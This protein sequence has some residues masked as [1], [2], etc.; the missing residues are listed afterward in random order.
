[1]GTQTKIL[2]WFC[3]SERVSSLEGWVGS[4]Q[5]GSNKLFDSLVKY[6]RDLERASL[7]IKD[8]WQTNGL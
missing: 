5:K 4:Y 3:Q 7:V 6:Y 2:L 8:I 1:M